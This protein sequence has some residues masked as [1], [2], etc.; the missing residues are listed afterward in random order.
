MEKRR[1]LYTQPT[2]EASTKLHPEKS[3]AASWFVKKHDLLIKPPQLTEEE[4]GA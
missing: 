1:I 3:L 4:V 2:I